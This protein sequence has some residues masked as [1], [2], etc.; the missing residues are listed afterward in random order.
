MVVTVAFLA[1]V[2]KSEIDKQR[3]Q[4]ASSSA[5]S[6]RGRS[7]S[8]YKLLLGIG[9]GNRV[10][11]TTEVAPSNTNR[12]HPPDDYSHLETNV[13]DCRPPPGHTYSTLDTPEN[14]EHS[15]EGTEKDE[16]YCHLREK[17]VT[18]VEVKEEPGEYSHLRTEQ[19]QNNSDIA[20]STYLASVENNKPTPL[21]TYVDVEPQRGASILPPTEWRYEGVPPAGSILPPTEWRYEGVPLAGSIL[22]PTDN[23]GLITSDQRPPTETDKEGV[24]CNNQGPPTEI[25]KKG[26]ACNNQGPPTDDIVILQR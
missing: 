6:T 26:V 24:A 11:Q 9:R 15:N 2:V 1:Y 14:G 20:N 16:R 3:Q 21:Y 23:K 10:R 17:R 4:P 5:E 19:S 7:R 18:Q 12:E 8:I 13:T 22:P 25:Y